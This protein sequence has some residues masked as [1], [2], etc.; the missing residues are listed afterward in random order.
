[1]AIKACFDSKD[2]GLIHSSWGMDVNFEVECCVE[3]CSAKLERTTDF[4]T[5]HEGW[6]TAFVQ[7]LCS[8]EGW[9]Y[10]FEKMHCYCPK[11]IDQVPEYSYDEDYTEDFEDDDSDE[12]E[13]PV[14][15]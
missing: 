15:A 12:L 8:D 5:A 13:D 9:G 3:G 11:H 4:A 1:M 2:P 14:D 6:G 7:Q 10:D